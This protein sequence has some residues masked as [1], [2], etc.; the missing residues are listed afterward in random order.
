MPVHGY[1]DSD[2]RTPDIRRA[3]HVNSDLYRRPYLQLIASA[4]FTFDGLCR[5]PGSQAVIL[6]QLSVQK[7]ACV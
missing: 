6:N 4:S 1:R 5:A 7:L 3:I 2:W